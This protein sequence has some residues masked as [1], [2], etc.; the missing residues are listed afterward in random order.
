M[1]NQ[2]GNYL[3][4]TASCMFTYAMIKGVNEGR[5]DKKYRIT[6]PDEHQENED[7]T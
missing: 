2:E 1:P 3:E 6:V 7:Y 5:L 4:S